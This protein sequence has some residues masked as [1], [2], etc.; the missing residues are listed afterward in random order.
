MDHV[1]VT[2]IGNTSVTTG[3]ACNGEISDVFRVPTRRR[4]RT[5]IRRVL[6]EYVGRRKIE[7]S[8]LCSVVPAVTAAWVAALRSVSRRPPL[9]VNHRLNLGIRI[10]YPKPRFIGADRLANACGAFRRY[11]APVIVADFGTALTFDVVSAGRAYV[12]G[13]IVPGPQIMMDYLAERTALLPRLNPGRCRR[14]IG[15]STA[16]A[17]TIGAR[18]GYTGMVRELIRGLRKEIGARVP[19]YATGGYAAW[20]VEGLHLPVDPD[21]TLFGLGEI[22]RLNSG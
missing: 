14:I 13:I 22:Y 18:I 3:L 4:D 16:E 8:V 19:I 2:D 15:K 20:A 6:A 10:E 7:G 5:E 17:M 11:G 9:I 1:I 12:G 21:L